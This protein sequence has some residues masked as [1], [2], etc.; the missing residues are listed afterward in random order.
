MKNFDKKS[1]EELIEKILQNDHE[2]QGE[3]YSRYY[4]VAFNKCVSMVKDDDEAFDLAQEAI[5]KAFDGLKYFRGDSTFSTW[6]YIIT[7]RCCLQALRKR[8]KNIVYVDN[9][10]LSKEPDNQTEYIN[11]SID[12]TE[13][14]DIMFGLI[15]HLP[16]EERELLI[17]KYYKGESIKTLQKIYQISSSA[18]KMRLKRSK[19][20]L[21]QSFPL[22]L[23]MS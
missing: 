19:E 22:A 15:N 2:A 9:F 14:N 1:D 23:A 4:H 20:K 18:I 11:E 6:L 16:A 5:L 21:N 10:I 17:Q 8:S 12:Q 13:A 7:H 3:L